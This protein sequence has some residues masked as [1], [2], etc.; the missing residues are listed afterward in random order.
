MLWGRWEGR[1]GCWWG[2]MGEGV[3]VGG[4]CGGADMVDSRYCRMIE[5]FLDFGFGFGGGCLIVLVGIFY[6]M[7]PGW[8]E[9][10]T[11]L[12]RHNQVGTYDYTL[13]RRWSEVYQA[14]HNQSLDN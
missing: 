11:A 5:E 12:N 14:M 6:G 7:R 10:I 8:L 2:E 4:D 1:V 3:V 9:Q 13:P